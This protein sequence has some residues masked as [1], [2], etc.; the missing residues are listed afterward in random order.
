MHPQTWSRDWLPKMLESRSVKTRLLQLISVLLLPS[1][2]LLASCSEDPER[3]ALGLVVQD[4]VDKEVLRSQNGKRLQISYKVNLPFPAAAIG[5]DEAQRLQHEGWKPCAGGN[6]DWGVVADAQEK[7][8]VHQLTRHWIRDGDLLTANMR[9]LSPLAEPVRQ[10]TLPE[11]SVQHV[12]ILLDR[13][14]AAVAEVVTQ[15]K[16]GC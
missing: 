1:V 10:G 14:G 16:L 3:H 2:F 11:G 4:A 12:T 15:L 8:L 5:K 7:R 9:Y 13:Y 6:T